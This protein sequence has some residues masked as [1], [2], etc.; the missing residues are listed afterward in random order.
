VEQ[1]LTAAQKV[2][3]HNHVSRA[4]VQR[5]IRLTHLIPELQHLVDAGGLKLRNAVE[6]SYIDAESQRGVHKAFYLDKG[7]KVNYT[8]SR[9]IRRMRERGT[10]L[11]QTLTELE[12]REREG[13]ANRER[14]RRKREAQAP[15]V[16]QMVVGDA[17][18][19]QTPPAPA[20]S[21]P[22]WKTSP[23]FFVVHRG[24]IANILR[25]APPDN[26]TLYRMFADFLK[27]ELGANMTLPRE[28]VVSSFNNPTQKKAWE[29]HMQAMAQ[30]TE[31][32]P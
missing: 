31:K 14:K 1:K 8:Q 16:R 9:F 28:A 13:K 29:K 5:Y 22:S 4:D 21:E 19:A 30:Q 12:R 3:E 15:Q 10:S 26:K 7:S 20:P 18:P 6:L 32:R 17:A 27:R 24:A 25:G 2:A 11:T 23:E